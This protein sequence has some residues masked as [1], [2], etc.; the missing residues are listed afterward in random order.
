MG[1]M[2]FNQ[3]FFSIEKEEAWLNEMSQ[4]GLRFVRKKGV[5][6]YEFEE[7]ITGEAYH[8]YVDKRPFCKDNEEY[9]HFLDELNIKLVKKWFWNYYF[10]TADEKAA[11]YIYTDRESRSGMYIR[12][13]LSCVVIT[14]FNFMLLYRCISNI[15]E[16]GGGP[17]LMKGPHLPDISIPITVISI[18]LIYM[19]L[20]IGN[21]IRLLYRLNHKESKRKQ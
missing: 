8:Y 4:K 12:C 14:L 7:N 15:P 1:R 20:M 6:S 2:V 11:K 10:E 17:W 13:M 21:Y 19:V 18:C 16:G 9:V 3:F 5:F